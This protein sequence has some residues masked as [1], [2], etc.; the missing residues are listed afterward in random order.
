MELRSGRRLRPPQP[1]GARCQRRR[2]PEEVQADRIS[3]L[4]DEMLLLVLARLGCVRAAVQTSLLSRRWRGLWTGLTDL[5]FRRLEPTTIEAVLAR[6]AHISAVSVYDVPLPF[7]N[8]G[9]DAAA[10]ANSFLCAAARLSPGK[11]VFTLPDRHFYV[12]K[13]ELPCFPSTASIDLDTKNFPV[14][15]MS[16]GEFAALERLFLSGRINCLCDMLNH[17]PR[18]RVLSVEA[19]SLQERLVCVMPPPVHE[20]TALESLSLT[21]R[22][23]GL[24]S[25]LNCCRHLHVLSIT[26][27][28]SRQL[29][30]PS[31]TEFPVLEKL[32][33]SGNIV[34]LTTSVNRC[35]RL[36]VLRVTFYGVKIRP[37]EAALTRLE[38]AGPFGFQLSL[39]GFKHISQGHGTN[40]SCFASLLRI[41]ARLSPQ[42][43]LFENCSSQL[44]IQLFPSFHCTTSIQIKLGL[45]ISFK[46]LPGSHF[47]VLERLS[48]SGGSIV[49]L[50]TMVTLC[51]RLCELRVTEARG[52]I[53][54][55]S[56]SL[57]KLS[58]STD[59]W[60]G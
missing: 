50:G 2:G 7:G 20:F 59:K 16:S 47:T 27:M 43:F 57:Q 5:A 35:P 51:P 49:D 54:F 42:E 21:G 17:C 56:G 36:R 32:S 60:T 3:A 1:H 10:Q 41:V 38:V 29:T 33:L 9:H 58:V 4:P 8:A 44:T 55:H 48:L 45:W 18:L 40:A 34:G 31:D 22:I 15:L 12:A 26:Y 23:D 24:C 13:I 37:I 28:D 6:F 52:N 25:L 46:V 11:L 39:L 19:T 53:K 14:E 30:L